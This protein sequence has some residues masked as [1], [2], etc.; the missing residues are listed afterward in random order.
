MNS[1]VQP[2][3]V[4]LDRLSDEQKRSLL[5]K[6][7]QDARRTP[8]LSVTQERIWQLDQVAPGNPVYNFQSALELRGALDP[9]VLTQAL[10]RIVQRH[11]T[12]RTSY[13]SAQG[14]PRLQVLPTLA[15]SA[16]HLDWRGE[17]ADQHAARLQATATQAARTGFKLARPPLFRLQCI[18]LEDEC[19]VLVLT[20]HHIVSDLISLDLF[21]NELGQHFA[22]L[23]AGEGAA[24]APLAWTYL[25]HA[26]AQQAQRT[27]LL[28]GPAA[29]F[30][31]EHLQEVS[32][33]VWHSDFPR[34]A[35]PDGQAATV[36][37]D[38]PA[39]TVQAV[40]ALARSHRVTPFVVLLSAWYVLQWA[41]SGSDDQV[42]CVP[43]AGRDRIELQPMIGMFS[44]PLPMR[45]DLS[46]QPDVA[47]LLRRVN[48]T[49]LGVAEHA[50][51]PFADIVDLAQH[52]SGKAPALRTM[53]SFVSR[54]K[55]PE[56]PGLRVQRVGTDRGMSDFDLF[57]TLYPD[58]GG[59]HGVF[60]YSTALFGAGTAQG[61]AR[62]YA[63][64]VQALTAEPAATLPDL[65][66]RVPVPQPLQIAV[67][68]TFTAELLEDAATFWQQELRWPTRLV[69]APYNQVFQALLDPASELHRPGTTLN[70][71]LVRPEDWIRYCNG[72]AQRR[73]TLAKATADFITAVRQARLRA[74]LALYLCPAGAG[75]PDADAVAIAE[76]RIRA[77]LAGVS[78]VTVLDAAQA[79]S[80]YAVVDVFDSAA[81]SAGHIPFTHAWFA[82][83]STELVRRAASLKRPP[84]K[85]LALDCDNTLWRGVVGEDGAQG[86]TV[87][88]PLRALQA[89]AAAQADA[90][91]LLCLVS[92]NEPEDVFRVFDENTGMLLRRDQIVAHRINWLPKSANLRTLA[93][94]LQLG[95]DSF[96]FIDDNPVECAEVRAACPE[97]L[98][99]CLPAD[100][101]TIPGFLQH[102]WAFDRAHV[103]A[104]DRQRAQSYLQ[105]R[106]R[107]ALRQEVSTFND[108]LAKLAL[109]VDLTPVTEAGMARLAQLSQ[110]TNQFNNSG[111]RYDEP[112]LRDALAQGQQALT[113]SV[114]DRFG[115]Y[116]LVGA[117][118][119]EVQGS[120]LRADS[121]MLSCRVLGRGVEHRMLAELGRIALGHGAAEVHVVF[122]ELPRNQPFRR[123]LASL[124]GRY[125][126]ARDAYLISAEAALAAT[127]DP[128]SLEAGTV[129]DGAAP[130]S[131][132]SDVQ[133]ARVTALAGT[134]ATLH[135]AEAILAR[136]EQG[137]PKV[138]GTVSGL[139]PQGATEQAIADIWHDVLH[140]DALGREDNF[141]EVGGNSLRL[142]QVNTRLME[143]LKREIPVT[144]LFQYPTIASLAQ[145]LDHADQDADHR[146]QTQAR[147]NQA[148]QK[149]AQRMQRLGSARRV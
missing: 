17:P 53:F 124:A 148:R 93:A 4:A 40:E 109:Q 133:L 98:T 69:F 9:A 50:A 31:R 7:L 38:L 52:G 86:V 6:L 12:L 85:V 58:H 123:F 140:I 43:S 132:A 56:F 102:V 101:S 39:P 3:G 13:A 59:W 45:V 129:Q 80:R 46:G 113:V 96:V 32:E 51:L 28:Q 63:D 84:F 61:W 107:E 141:F 143:H 82:A 64:I 126:D 44:S 35:R 83:M 71:L 70:V 42:V 128:Q 49:V 14:Q 127:F 8:T 48:A 137:R 87:S 22:A 115:D 29:A 67:A 1:I 77:E 100:V 21:F 142:V 25:D 117:M 24:P 135:S 89:F 81:D 5:A 41:A 37:V 66:A 139:P 54:M 19:H 92:K 88:E 74:P 125:S 106:Q 95:L 91:M 114:R 23:A 105:N 76:E 2:P 97:V 118:V 11:D 104:E 99:L 131:T 57:L 149:L 111:R 94:E 112:G 15:V 122:K 146:E 116:G 73:E 55:T 134:A 110:R 10:A 62:A 78:G 119:C 136:I 138:R 144:T 16:E 68:A 75:T 34:P 130:G 121:F 145:H 20:M 27:A 90:G 65:A 26:R 33:L 72:S 147:A 36:H 30:W 60:E 79:L 108:F 120:V 18:R 47:G 103:S